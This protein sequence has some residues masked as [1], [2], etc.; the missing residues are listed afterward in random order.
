MDIQKTVSELARGNI[1]RLQDALMEMEKEHGCEC[2]LYHHFAPGLYAREIFLLKDSLVIGKIHKHAHVN[3]IS[4]GRVIVYTEF[5]MEEL[6]APYQFVS[7][8]GTKRVV[9]ALEDTIWTTYHPM[10]ETDLEKCEE[11]V[12][13]KTFEEYEQFKIEQDKKLLEVKP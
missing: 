8:P 1:I 10:E 9:L 5:G 2:P 4:Q 11:L 13:A 7:Q 3:N 12:I 6:I